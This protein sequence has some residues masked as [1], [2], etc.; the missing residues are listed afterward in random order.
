VAR[1]G[2]SGA[3]LLALLLGACAPEAP[4]LAELLCPS[5]AELQRSSDPELISQWCR[6]PD[7]KEVGT[8]LTWHAPGRLA[9]VGRVES[10]RLVGWAMF[11]E[12]GEVQSQSVLRASDGREVM[13]LWHRDG[14]LQAQTEWRANLPDGLHETWHA[15]GQL[16]ATGHYRRGKQ[17]GRWT[18]GNANGQT[19]VVDYGEA[20]SGSAVPASP[21]ERQD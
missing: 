12:T 14:T 20:A 4:G 6:T 15:N 1:P 18:L 10:G 3:A 17:V 9:S 8:A 16:R 21:E 11:Y 5:G 13:R 19:N 7:G 2:I